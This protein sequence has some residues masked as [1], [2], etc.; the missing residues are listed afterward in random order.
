MAQLISFDGT[1]ALEGIFKYEFAYQAINFK[2]Y[3]DSW[4]NVIWQIRNEW[5]FAPRFNLVRAE[6]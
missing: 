6:A 1:R 2:L 5:E 4:S 3:D